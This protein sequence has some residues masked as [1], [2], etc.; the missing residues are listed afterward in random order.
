MGQVT[1][2]QDVVTRL[3]SFCHRDMATAWMMFDRLIAHRDPYVELP[4]GSIALT[5]EQ[6]DEFVERFNSEVEPHYWASKQRKN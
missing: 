5:E 3:I 4:G 2:D 1:A 6:L